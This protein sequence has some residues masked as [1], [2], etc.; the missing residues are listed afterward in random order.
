[1]ET[2]QNSLGKILFLLNKFENKFE[3]ANLSLLYIFLATFFN[4][5]G[6]LS[7]K[8]MLLKYSAFQLTYMVSLTC[9]LLTQFFRLGDPSITFTIRSSKTLKFIL[10]RSF[11]SV[12]GQ[13]VCFFYLSYYLPLSLINVIYG[14]TPVLVFILDRI[15]YHTPL[16]SNEI[17]GSVL[18]F[19]GISLIID[20]FRWGGEETPSSEFKNEATG[21][22]RVKY[23]LLC[24]LACVGFAFANIVMKEL[25]NVSPLVIQFHMYVFGIMFLPTIGIFQGGHFTIMEFY[26]LIKVIC[27]NGLLQFFFM[28]LFTRALQLGKKGKVVV[29]N[30][31]QLLYSF[32]VEIVFFNQ[33]PTWIRLLGSII[34]IMGISGAVL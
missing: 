2:I 25:H 10:M 1:M 19:V 30:N 21:Y 9:I 11:F 14:F 23:S 12:T 27:I 29:V 20:L 26:D 32:T 33:P 4:F 7:A 13:M 17:I 6:S 15:I 28:L 24:L 18:S 31:L 5:F 8:Y 3:P 34:L 22:E 16:K